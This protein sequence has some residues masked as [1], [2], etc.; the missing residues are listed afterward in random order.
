MN[1]HPLLPGRRTLAECGRACTLARV[2]VRDVRNAAACGD[3]DPAPVSGDATEPRT[4]G[5][6]GSRLR[7]PE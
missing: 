1:F 3:Q 4:G 5:R 6:I 2:L 7:G